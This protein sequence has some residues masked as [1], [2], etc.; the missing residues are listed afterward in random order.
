ME[1]VTDAFLRVNLLNSE[2]L[3]KKMHRTVQPIAAF[4]CL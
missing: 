3:Q 1:A 2:E 4:G